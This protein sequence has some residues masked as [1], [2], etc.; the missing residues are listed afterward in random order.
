MMFFLETGESVNIS[1]LKV[2]LAMNS[3]L[4]FIKDG[5]LRYLRNAIVDYDTLT[6][7]AEIELRSSNLIARLF[8]EE[9]FADIFNE[10]DTK[11]E[12]VF[13]EEHLL[14]FSRANR[15]LDVGC[16]IGRLLIPLHNR[17]W[18]VDGIDSSR[19]IILSL[20]NIVDPSNGSLYSCDAANFLSPKS[21]DVAFS[22]CNSIRYLSTKSRIIRH[23]KNMSENLNAGGLYLINFT[24]TPNFER[25]YFSQRWSV[26]KN[27]ESYNYSWMTNGMNHEMNTIEEF[28]VYDSSS[29]SEQL[30]EIQV[31]YNF[32]LENFT[33][34]LEASGSWIIENVWDS[35][36]RE[37]QG[38]SRNYVGNVWI[39]LKNNI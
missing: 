20:S 9:Q 7:K 4:I 3:D 10:A 24:M 35:Q 17:G 33:E 21:Y 29:S 34:I 1:D 18:R 19:K 6:Q 15:S 28:V 36:F 25:S 26:E 23:F 37:V 30:S 22:A 12:V 13:I 16:G 27:G 5:S 39:L 11:A 32:N 2:K 14:K 8:D 31:Q 38:L